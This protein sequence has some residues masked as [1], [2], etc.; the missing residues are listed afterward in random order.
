[1][2]LSSPLSLHSQDHLFILTHELTCL[3]ALTGWH[4]TQTDCNCLV[5]QLVRATVRGDP[6]LTLCARLEGAE[7]QSTKRGKGAKLISLLGGSELER[8]FQK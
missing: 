8:A 6:S 3:P 7:S 2:A 1:M 4:P 5:S